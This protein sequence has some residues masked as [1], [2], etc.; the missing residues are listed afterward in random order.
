MTFT[1]HDMKQE[2]SDGNNGMRWRASVV[3]QNGLNKTTD[4]GRKVLGSSLQNTCRCEADQRVPAARRA[5][6]THRLEEPRMCGFREVRDRC[7]GGRP[8]A[9]RQAASDRGASSAG[10]GAKTSLP[11][12]R[13]G[14]LKHLIPSRR[15][16]I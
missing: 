9:V 16:R 1:E 4:L 7:L 6:P 5:T 14:W 13:R 15:Q 2:R 12:P 10:G 8:D 11:S 3:A